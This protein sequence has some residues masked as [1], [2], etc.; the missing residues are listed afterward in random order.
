MRAEMQRAGVV[1]GPR[2]YSTGSILYG[3]R[4]PFSSYVNNLDDALTHLNR[5]KAEGAF[6]TAK[7]ISRWGSCSDQ[8]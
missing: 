3:A 6:R 5:Q 8:S 1:V 4:T 7:L 2:I